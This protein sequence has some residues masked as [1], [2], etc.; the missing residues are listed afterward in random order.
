MGQG[1]QVSLD[2]Y[3]MPIKILHVSKLSVVT[4]S[5]FMGF[6]PLTIFFRISACPSLT[7][8]RASAYTIWLTCDISQTSNFLLVVWMDSIISCYL[9]GW[10]KPPLYLCVY[11]TSRCVIQVTQIYPPKKTIN[12]PS[13]FLA[14][15]L[16]SLPK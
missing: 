14:V 6:L 1:S 9:L 13:N 10:L 2:L 12:Y 16:R 11:L 7:H 3:Y 5:K 8:H 4:L 15:K